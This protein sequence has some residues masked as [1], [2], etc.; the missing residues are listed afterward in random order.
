MLWS[1]NGSNKFKGALKYPIMK[2]NKANFVCL[3][4]DSI[5]LNAV[6]S[7]TSDGSKWVNLYLG[8]NLYTNSY[9]DA[10]ELAVEVRSGQGILVG[11]DE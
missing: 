2:T 6:S 10:T 7:S 1:L 9:K 5:S 11:T 4:V 3:I 8:L